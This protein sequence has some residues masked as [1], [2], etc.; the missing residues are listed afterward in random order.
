MEFFKTPEKQI[1][2]DDSKNSPKKTFEIKK[3]KKHIIKNI[4]NLN[5]IH[6]NLNIPKKY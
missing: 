1:I 6:N 4:F 5:I 2:K 3:S